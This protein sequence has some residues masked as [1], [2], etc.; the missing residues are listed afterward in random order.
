MTTWTYFSDLHSI[1]N[2]WNI[3]TRGSLEKK[4]KKEEK[5]MVEA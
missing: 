3:E 2:K 4:K 1:E 5:E